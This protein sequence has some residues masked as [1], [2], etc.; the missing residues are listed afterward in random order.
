V[1]QNK[2]NC[3]GPSKKFADRKHRTKG[4]KVEEPE[5]EKKVISL[6]QKIQTANQ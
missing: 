6:H 5:G 3:G 4:M 2:T 1:H